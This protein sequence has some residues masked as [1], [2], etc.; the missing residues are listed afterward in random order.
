MLL[1]PVVQKELV[2]IVYCFCFEL[3]ILIVCC[4]E[5]PCSTY[6]FLGADTWLKRGFP[7]LLLLKKVF[8]DAKFFYSS[9]FTV[10][11][12]NFF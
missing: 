9:Y 8:E 6:S 3:S 1:V 11:F 12:F 2:E 4:T 5:G 10:L 7:L